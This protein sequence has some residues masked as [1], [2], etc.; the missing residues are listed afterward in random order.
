[1]HTTIDSGYSHPSFEKIAIAYGIEY[2]AIREL[3]Q[4]SIELLEDKPQIIELFF[5]ES[6]I[7]QQSLPKGY[8]C[9]M[10]VPEISR[11]TYDYLNGL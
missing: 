9:Q 10:F 3:R 5:D 11:E 6:C 8:P 7:I 1:M 4:F 2:T